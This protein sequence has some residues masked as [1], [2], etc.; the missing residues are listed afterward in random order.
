V[1][2]RVVVDTAARHFG[3]DA[4]PF[5]TLLDLREQ[6]LKAKEVEPEPLF[7]R[8]MIQIDKVIDAVDVLAK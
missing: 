8:Y 6:K 2:R 4:S 3:I 1:H 7:G 5:L